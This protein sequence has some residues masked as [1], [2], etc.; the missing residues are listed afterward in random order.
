VV[1]EVPADLRHRVTG[2]DLQSQLHRARQYR[3]VA[4]ALVVRR[5]RRLR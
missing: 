4:L 5:L 1:A 3:D 2:R